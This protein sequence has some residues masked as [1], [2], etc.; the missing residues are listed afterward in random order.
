MPSISCT[1]AP[2]AVNS[3][4][5]GWCVKNYSDWLTSGESFTV[6]DGS[7]TIQFR[8]V[9]S[10]STPADQ[11]IV[12]SGSD[13]ALTGT[14]GAVSWPTAW[15]PPVCMCYWRGQVFTG[16]CKL[17]TPGAA[18]RR[19]RW[20]EIGAFRFLGATANPLRNEAGEWYMGDS[21]S[22][23]VMRLIPFEDIMVVYGTYSTWI[24]IPV[25]Q[26]APAFNFKQLAW[27]GIKNP[28]A[29]AGSRDKQVCID[30]EGF[31]RVLTGSLRDGYTS[32]VIGYDSIF[33]SMQ[34]T[35]NMSTGVGIISVVYNPDDDEFYISNGTY[36]YIFDGASLC[37]IEKAYTSYINMRGGQLTSHEAAAYL[38]KPMSAVTSLAAS[39]VLYIATET[40]D[41]GTS[42]IKTIMSVEVVGVFGTSAV[43]QVMVAYRNNRNAAYTTTGW[44]RTNPAGVAF[45]IVSGVDFRIYVQADVYTGTIIDELKIE[46]QLVDK[47]TVRGNYTNAGSAS[48][49]ADK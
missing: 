9:E 40:I 34:T 48:T 2:T 49:N 3:I 44:K 27:T 30:R 47:H 25:Q 1:L 8:Y 36:S 39:P 15:N 22:E 23:M 46:W 37:Q 35:V 19:V 41:F 45:P 11:N 7:Y 38:S 6:V 43:V 5:S 18:A 12:V 29:V 33:A 14:Y 13:Q 32:K 21:D 42:S 20:S 10:Y 28:L 4:N 17:T 31:L 24:M 26:P 16:G